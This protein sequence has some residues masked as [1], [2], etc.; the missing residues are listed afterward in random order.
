M[1]NIWIALVVYDV[2]SLKCFVYP[3]KKLDKKPNTFQ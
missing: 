1:G 3:Q 2:S